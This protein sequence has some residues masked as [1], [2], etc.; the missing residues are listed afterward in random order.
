MTPL[1]AGGACCSSP[2]Q[3]EVAS[4]VGGDLLTTPVSVDGADCSSSL[5]TGRGSSP[6]ESQSASARKRASLRSS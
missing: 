2:W 3:S 5:K 6:P 1:T 4:P